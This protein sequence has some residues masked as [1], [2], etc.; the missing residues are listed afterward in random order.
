[1]VAGNSMKAGN[2]LKAGISVGMNKG[3]IVTKRMP[4]KKR[5]AF[6]K[7]KL[8]GRGELVKKV[9]DEVCGFAPYEKR[10]LELLRIGKDK[11]A[12]KFAKKRLGTHLRA[13]RKREEM[14][15]ALRSKRG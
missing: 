9:V 11:R 3:H 2:G 10:I 15:E 12:L 7:G 4:A 14:S 6:K 1:M 5:S 13:K 8:T